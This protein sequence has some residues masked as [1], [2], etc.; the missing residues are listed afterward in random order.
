MARQRPENTLLRQLI[1]ANYRSVE[2]FSRENCCS[3]NMVRALIKLRHSPYTYRTLAQKIADTFGLSITDLFPCKLYGPAPI[4]QEP[5]LKTVPLTQE[6]FS[7]EDLLAAESITAR[8]KYVEI[9][10]LVERVL[11]TLT[12]QQQ[13]VL[14]YH[15]FEELTPT[16]IARRLK[17]APLFTPRVVAHSLA[18]FKLQLEYF[19]PSYAEDY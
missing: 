8:L 17:L 11:G 14:R 12:P 13:K 3:P 9:K 10:K 7:I 1:A 19:A 18:A 5:L 4:A 16:E 2:R 6:H 15:Y